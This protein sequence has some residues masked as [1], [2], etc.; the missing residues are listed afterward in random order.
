MLVLNDLSSSCKDHKGHSD[1]KHS[2]L[3]EV[4]DR[5]MCLQD[6]AGYVPEAVL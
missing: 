1:C 3:L 4:R 6:C 2:T 5:M